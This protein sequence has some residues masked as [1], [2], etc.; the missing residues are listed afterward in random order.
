MHAYCAAQARRA[1]APTNWMANRGYCGCGER[2]IRQ[3]ICAS[4]CDILSS[5]TSEEMEARLMSHAARML[6]ARAIVL[7]VCVLVR[8]GGTH[9]V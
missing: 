2:E 8:C 5:K 7:H 6:I 1:L 3:S 4:S 9:K